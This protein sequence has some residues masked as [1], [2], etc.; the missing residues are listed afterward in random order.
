[1]K[2]ADVMRAIHT[3]PIYEEIR[4]VMGEDLQGWNSRAPIL[5]ELVAKHRPATIIDV[6]VW[7]GASTLYLA[8][9]LRDNGIDGCVIAV[10]TFL[11]SPEHWE[12]DEQDLPDRLHGRPQLYEQFLSNVVRSGLQ[13]Y[14]VPLPQT[15]VNAAAILY[16][17]EIYADLVHI[18]AA[19]DYRS[20]AHDAITYWM[21]LNSGGW[22][23]GDD[24]HSA[25]PGVVQAADDFA[26]NVR[27]E[28]IV[29]ESYKWM[30]RKP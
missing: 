11:G 19:H 20:V 2:A 5:A 6:G 22:L 18:D 4:E 14:I 1:M 24:Y 17:R 13:R 23:V 12:P 7:K 9:A 30:V 28:L 26:A 25:C 8:E 15:S 21:L 3:R 27:C 29:D 10:D 16:Q